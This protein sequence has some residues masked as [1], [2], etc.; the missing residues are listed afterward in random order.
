MSGMPSFFAEMANDDLDA[1]VRQRLRE[2]RGERGLTLQQVAQRA[3]IDVSTLSRLEAGKRRLALDHLPGL[4]RALGVSAD[5]LL[6]DAPRV[7]PRV[8]SR[9]IRRDQL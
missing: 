2:L 4:A 3:N 7:D 9:A 8:R 6:A 1:R 5:D